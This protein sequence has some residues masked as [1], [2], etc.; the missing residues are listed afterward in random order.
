MPQH[1]QIGEFGE[2]VG[3]EDQGCQVR[4]GGREGGLY[5]GDSVAREEE[6]A[7]ARGEGEVGEGGDVVVGEVDGILV[8]EMR[9]DCFSEA[10]WFSAKR[11]S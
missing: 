11:I 10:V 9:E 2:I 7:E 3:C 4:Q 5:G 6:G 8:L 1:V